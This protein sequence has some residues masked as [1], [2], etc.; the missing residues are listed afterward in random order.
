MRPPSRHAYGEQLQAW[1]LRTCD[2]PA[3]L[4]ESLFAGRLFE[5]RNFQPCVEIAAVAGD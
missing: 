5:G 1:A 2:G 4:T 3:D